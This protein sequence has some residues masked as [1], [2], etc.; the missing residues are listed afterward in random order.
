MRAMLEYLCVAVIPNIPPEVK[1]ETKPDET[2]QMNVLVKRTDYEALERIAK[3]RDLSV[4]Q[5]VRS[6]IRRAVRGSEA[7]NEVLR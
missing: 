5:L 7:R 6:L 3:E 2:K 1:M 4:A